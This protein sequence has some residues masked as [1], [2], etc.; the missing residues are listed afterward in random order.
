MQNTRLTSEQK[1]SDQL[2]SLEEYINDIPMAIDPCKIC[3]IYKKNDGYDFAHQDE[4]GSWEKGP[5]NE[6][7]WFYASNFEAGGT[8]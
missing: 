6:C 2:K 8:K 3:K 7:C 5:C 4:K 1:I